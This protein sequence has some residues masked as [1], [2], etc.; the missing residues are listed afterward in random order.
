MINV[1][2]KHSDNLQGR[3]CDHYSNQNKI[4]RQMRERL[5]INFEICIT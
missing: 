1:I 5:K 2:D 3:S 4:F